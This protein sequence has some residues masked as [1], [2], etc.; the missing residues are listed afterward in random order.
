MPFLTEG[1][2]PL[3]RVP[4]LYRMGRDFQV[5]EGFGWLD[6]R[7]VATIIPVPAHDTTQPPRVGNSTDFASVPPA[8]W[9]LIASY[10]KQ[11]LPAILHDHLAYEATVAPVAE[12]L[13]LRK[14]ADEVFR[15]ALIDSGVNRL[16]ARV[17]WAAVGIERY[18]R[19]AGGLGIL[20]IAQFVL[21]VAAVIASVVL[22]IVATPLWFLLVL[23]PG[24]LAIPWWR[25]ADLMIVLSYVGA[26][27]APLV[28]AAFIAARLEQVLATVV[29]VFNGCP[30][31][32]PRAEPTL[33]W[34]TRA[35]SVG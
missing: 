35:E 22:G 23:A 33:R 7:D 29:W 34:P 30:G 31:S 17:M 9:G 15:I 8:L 21:G 11:T 24:V 2:E 28:I 20:L 3:D 18:A 5:T 16:R 13:A 32:M 26:L 6:P 10:G 4:L 25:N 19:H 14:T 12:R 1:G 27:Y